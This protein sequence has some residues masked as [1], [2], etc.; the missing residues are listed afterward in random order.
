MNILRLVGYRPWQ[1][2]TILGRLPAFLTGNLHWVTGNFSHYLRICYRRYL[3]E[4]DQLKK[5]NSSCRK[6]ILVTSIID[7]RQE[8]NSCANNLF[9]CDKNLFPVTSFYFIT[10]VFFEKKLIF[11]V[12]IN[13][14]KQIISWDK[15]WCHCKTRFLSK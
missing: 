14:H 6:L 12:I 8:F 9:F 7:L 3:I 15:K 13:L 4:W 2:V 1:A 5:E 10:K 11:S